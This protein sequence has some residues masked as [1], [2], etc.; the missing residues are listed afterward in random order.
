MSITLLSIDLLQMPF[1]LPGEGGG[2]DVQ[3]TIVDHYYVAGD[4]ESWVTQ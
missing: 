2:I 4:I 1:V 3:V